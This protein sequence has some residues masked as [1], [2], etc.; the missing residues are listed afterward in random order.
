[1]LSKI[2]EPNSSHLGAPHSSH[3]LNREPRIRLTLAKSKV[4]LFKFLLATRKLKVTYV[5]FWQIT[6]DGE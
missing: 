6:R 5:F 4:V 3:S 2:Y 1:M